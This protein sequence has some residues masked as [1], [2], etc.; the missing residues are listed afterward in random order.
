MKV[1]LICLLIP[2]VSQLKS[3][4]HA[5]DS[6]RKYS[7][8]LV[9]YSYNP[10]SADDK[11]SATNMTA[12]YFGTG[13]FIRRGGR[14]FFASAN[15]LLTGYDVYKNEKIDV[16]I[17]YLA[18]RYI[19]SSGKRAMFFV[20]VADVRNFTIPKS[21]LEEAD[22]NVLEIAHFPTNSMIYSLEDLLY[23][24]RPKARKIDGSKLISYGYPVAKKTKVMSDG[25]YIMGVGAS[26]Y[27]GRLGNTS[28]Y[29]P[30][31]NQKALK[32]NYLTSTPASGKGFSGA[33]V[34]Y[35]NNKG[36]RTWIEFAGIQ[37]GIN[38]KYNSSYIV[39]S[40]SLKKS[41]EK[42]LRP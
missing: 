5:L 32:S 14:L 12:E 25:V 18:I 22:A 24:N 15:H 27:E 16:K 2:F 9:A 23:T 17:D 1:L 29:D 3:Q 7:H 8:L 35:I 42:M 10:L 4:E 39:T 11:P 31:V 38:E 37:A 33:P 34:Y 41:I 6:L 20:K 19:D 13:F 40:E 36:K 21:F 28:T 26:L 30:E